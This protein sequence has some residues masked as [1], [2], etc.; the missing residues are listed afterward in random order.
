VIV[1]YFLM[2]VTLL[3]WPRQKNVEHLIAYSAALIVGTQFWYPQ[4][5]GVYLL[6][7]LPVLLM[8]VFRPRIAHL[9]RGPEADRT[10][11]VNALRGPHGEPPSRRSVSG[12][13]QRVQLFR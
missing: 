7:Y 3:I 4:Q 10:A 1:G 2:M 8:A 13:L 5:G 6:W 11:Q 9:Q 12:R